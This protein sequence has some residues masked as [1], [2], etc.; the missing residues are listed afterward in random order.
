VAIDATAEFQKIIH[1]KSGSASRNAPEGIVRQQTRHVGQK[2]LK[3]ASG[4]VIEDPIL[5]PGELPRHQLVL[6]A[7]KRMKEMGYA[8]SA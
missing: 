5:T 4:V 6:G 3:R 2:G 1:A 8:E 7:A